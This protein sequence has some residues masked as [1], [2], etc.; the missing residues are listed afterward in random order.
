MRAHSKQSTVGLLGNV[1]SMKYSSA[2]RMLPSRKHLIGLG[3]EKCGTTTAYDILSTSPY[4]SVP[5]SKE[6]FFFNRH[7]Q[8]GENYYID[9]YGIECKDR[10]TID[11]TPS[12]HN[13]TKALDRISAI[14]DDCYILL[15]LRDPIHRAFSLYRHDILHHF[16]VGERTQEHAG[17]IFSAPFEKRFCDIAVSYNYYFVD[18]SALIKNITDRFDRSRVMVIYFHEVESGEFV[19]KLERKIGESLD[20]QAPNGWSNQSDI[21]R[22]RLE[23]QGTQEFLCVDRG[24][25]SKV[26]WNFDKIGAENVL[27]A[28][29]ASQYWS[30]HVTL[31]EYDEIYQRLY[32]N[33]DY[34]AMDLD[35]R[36]I[37]RRR[38]I[39]I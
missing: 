9:L 5:K 36:K 30:E 7:Y 1:F 11:I 2:A 35:A 39:H 37:F 8:K 13:D 12:Y 3:L 34:A 29:A 22:Y 38:F 27:K 21:P 16:S 20:I 23:T 15:F 4:V 25:F 19:R 24:R 33:V 28:I 32:R 14:S 26:R 18:F 17:Q 31:K 6:T 10:I